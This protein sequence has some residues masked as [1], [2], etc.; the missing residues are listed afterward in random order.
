MTLWL[1]VIILTAGAVYRLWTDL[2]PPRVVN[3][4]LLPGTFAAQVGHVLGLLVTG[5]TI[6]NTALVKDDGSGEPQASAESR[7]RIPVLGPIIVAMLPMLACGLGM[8]AVA[9]WL[10][11][12]LPA[13]F[14]NAGVTDRLPTTIAA[15]C[16]LVRD[17]VTLV[18]R[19]IGRFG[20][21]DLSSWEAWVFAYLV[22]CL[23]VRMAP[24]TGQV[25]SALGA[26]VLLGVLS[27]LGG[28]VWPGWR[29]ALLSA[30]PMLSF[31]VATLLLLLCVSLVAR[32]VIELVKVMMPP[33]GRVAAS[34]RS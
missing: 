20:Q 27:A 25:R 13:A 19:L 21:R 15:G 6:N 17:V 24:L 29:G 14:A 9:A 5:A 7:T 2:V 12:D 31:A 8:Y 18:E 23:S 33:A 30:W 1:L 10:G 4:I 26:V 28:Q 32:G 22:V 34:R 16:D 3:S 11:A